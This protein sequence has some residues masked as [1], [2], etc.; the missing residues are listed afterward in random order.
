MGTTADKLNKLL[1]T[2]TAIKEA[3]KAKGVSVAETDTFRSY[4][5]KI[6]SI[7]VSVNNQDRVFDIDKN[8]SFE[9]T[10]DS[11]FS[12]LAKVTVNVQV[13][14]VKDGV[15]IQHIDG[16]LYTVVEWIVKEL[17]SDEANGVA[18]V[19]KT[20]K[21][22]I[23]KEDASDSAA[24]SS[25]QSKLTEGIPTTT[26]QSAALSNFD[27]KSYTKGMI[28]VDTGG[29]AFVCSNYLFPNGIKGY[30]P[31]L[32]EWRIVA[33]NLDQIEDAMATAGGVPLNLMGRTLW[34]SV[35]YNA[36]YAWR[37]A[38]NSTNRYDGYYKYM[39]AGV[40]AFAPLCLL[41][42]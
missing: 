14:L 33:D 4:A 13:P 22:V 17:P 3:I 28:A 10:P 24:W 23:A 5:D 8:G 42:K 1:E 11:G 26:T 30:L 12:G 20:V 32:G 15:Y 37:V 29:A 7:A 6:E 34:S 40:R 18:V 41:I 35:Q 39:K 2:K 19:T 21:F 9:L 27:G 31:S 36:N 16:S 25:V 38:L